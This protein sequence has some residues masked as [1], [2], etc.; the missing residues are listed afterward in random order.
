MY[1]YKLIS[2]LPSFTNI[3]LVSSCVRARARVFLDD[4]LE[5]NRAMVFIMILVFFG[6]TYEILLK[7][8]YEI[9]GHPFLDMLVIVSVFIYT[10]ETVMKI[11]MHIVA[12]KTLYKYVTGKRGIIAILFLYVCKVSTR[13]LCLFSSGRPILHA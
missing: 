1:M 13:S 4:V 5:G 10:L 7:L 12:F 3:L 6:L 9:E 11:V 8:V 2:H